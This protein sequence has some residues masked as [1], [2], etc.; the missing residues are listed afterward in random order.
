[1]NQCP[2]R[3]CGK[4]TPLLYIYLGVSYPTLRK[5][6]GQGRGWGQQ[7]WGPAPQN[8]PSF[9]GG[10]QN[11]DNSLPKPLGWRR[12]TGIKSLGLIS[13]QVIQRIKGGKKGHS[14]LISEMH[15]MRGKGKNKSDDSANIKSSVSI[16]L[17][18]HLIWTQQR[19]S[20]VETTDGKQQPQ[21]K[22]E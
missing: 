15:L 17:P 18:L 14:K 8:A 16:K 21:L 19:W 11:S 12:G 9:N 3:S 7:I 4:T 2:W 13:L 22:T 5:S 1:M 10:T 6:H 20:L